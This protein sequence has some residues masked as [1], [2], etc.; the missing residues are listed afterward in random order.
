MLLVSVTSNAQNTQKKNA[1]YVILQ[2]YALM[3]QGNL[4][5]IEEWSSIY[6]DI[7]GYF[8]GFRPILV[9]RDPE[10][11]KQIFIRNFDSF[12]KRQLIQEASGVVP[13]NTVKLSRI[14]GD[15]WRLIRALISTAFKSNKLKQAF[16]M[17]E[18]C[19]D[20]FLRIMEKDKAAQERG[21]I[22][23]SPA[24]C[25]LSL[26]ILLRFTMGARLN[27]QAASKETEAILNAGRNAARRFPLG[28]LMVCNLIPTWD[29]V[30]TVMVFLQGCLREAPT[31]MFNKYLFELVRQRR[32]RGWTETEDLFQL[33]FNAE[34]KCGPDRKPDGTTQSTEKGHSGNSDTTRTERT[35][36][37]FETAANV[38]FFVIAG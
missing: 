14:S 32:E 13:V 1:V 25:R 23:I 6:G 27:V 17:I 15:K 16:P 24:F 10:L 33:L 3:F 36:T 37:P 26:E 7:F 9:I 21:G 20:E 4:N 8:H 31:E 2:T 28:L 29:I 19:T 12:P 22:D 38:E 35:I 30:K 11:I 34:E 5:I 18:E